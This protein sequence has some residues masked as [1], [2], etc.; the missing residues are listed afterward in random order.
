MARREAAPLGLVPSNVE[1]RFSRSILDAARHRGRHPALVYVDS[2]ERS[3]RRAM[4]GG[5][6]PDSE[7]ADL[8][9]LCS[10]IFEHSHGLGNPFGPA[11]T[12]QAPRPTCTILRSRPS[13]LLRW[14]RAWTS[15]RGPPPT[16]P[17]SR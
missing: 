13:L 16:D 1:Q 14:F 8:F 5:I 2:A 15:G 7:T 9:E 11:H 6:G 3:C 12:R 10:E 17:E 4:H